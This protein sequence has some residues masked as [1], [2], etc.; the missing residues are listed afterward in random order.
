MTFGLLQYRCAYFCQTVDGPIHAV[1][2]RPNHV[3]PGHQY[4]SDGSVEPVQ[5]CKGGA[6]VATAGVPAPLRLGWERKHETRRV[7]HLCTFKDLNTWCRT[8]K[9]EHSTG[10]LHHLSAGLVRLLSNNHGNFG[11]NNSQY[12]RTKSTTL[13][14]RT[15]WFLCG[16]CTSVCLLIAALSSQ[17]GSCRVF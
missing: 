16:A 2:L 1:P 10:S 13:L 9:Q 3:V 6:A 4:L 12:W 17:H 7:R 8:Q 14:S 11:N 5:A 15:V